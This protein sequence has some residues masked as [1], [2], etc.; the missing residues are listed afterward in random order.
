MNIIFLLGNTMNKDFKNDDELLMP[1]KDTRR[2]KKEK[3]PVTKREVHP[4][5][6]HKK[7]KY[8]NDWTYDT[9]S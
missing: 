1:K 4:K 9:Q 3:K 5:N 2:K 8:P 6:I 7:E